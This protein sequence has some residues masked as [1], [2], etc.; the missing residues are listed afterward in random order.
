[1]TSEVWRLVHW[2]CLRE[3]QEVRFQSTL[4][5]MNRGFAIDLGAESL[6]PVPA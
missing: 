5:L 1:M 2:V 3:S 4:K 6:Q